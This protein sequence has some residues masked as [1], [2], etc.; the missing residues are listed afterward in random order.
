MG[1]NALLHP[2]NPMMLALLPTMTD[3]IVVW[4]VLALV[5]GLIAWREYTLPEISDGY[6]SAPAGEP[7]RAT[8]ADP[9]EDAT[10]L[11]IE[12]SEPPPASDPSRPP[13]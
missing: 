8:A 9:G 3:R 5:I 1:T 12:P 11:P 7:T 6:V 4:G 2:D 10:R 13:S